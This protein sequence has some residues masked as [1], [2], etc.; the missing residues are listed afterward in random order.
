VRDGTVTTLS[1]CFVVCWHIASSCVLLTTEPS[2]EWRKLLRDNSRVQ[3]RN[4]SV[5]LLDVDD[6]GR[7]LIDN[8]RDETTY[9][10]DGSWNR[11]RST[12]STFVTYRRRRIQLAWHR[13]RNVD[14]FK[15]CELFQDDFELIVNKRIAVLNAGPLSAFDSS[16]TDKMSRQ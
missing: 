11:R 3:R 5:L 7:P 1:R 16:N 9:S 8:R 2:R 6:A 15:R 4:V 13:I 14:T 10:A 12:L